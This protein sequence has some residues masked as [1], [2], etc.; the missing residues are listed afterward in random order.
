MSAADI[1]KGLQKARKS[2]GGW[3]ACCPAHDDGNPSLSLRDADGKILVH[4]HAGCDQDAIVGALKGLG[5]WPERGE[6]AETIEAIYDYTDEHGE[7]LYQ[8]VR[9]PGKK[10]LQRYPDE[11]GGWIWKKHP[12]QVL[13]HLREVLESPIVFVVE[14]EKDAEKLREHGFVATTNAGGAKAPWL[15]EFTAALA[16]REVILIPD[17]DGP[18][19]QRVLRIARALTGK[20]ARLIILTLEGHGVRDVSDWFRDHSEVELISMLDGEEVTR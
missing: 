15:Q 7:L 14:G 5:L 8:I 11:T 20:V 2:G 13:Y 18:G 3:V 9:K 16:G 12:R 10:F 17:N 4:C 19:R 6:Q 1:A